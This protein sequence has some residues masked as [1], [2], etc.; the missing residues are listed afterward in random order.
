MNRYLF[1]ICSNTDLQI[2]RKNI[3]MAVKRKNLVLNFQKSNISHREGCDKLLV[4]GDCYFYILIS[5]YPNE[6]DG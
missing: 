3:E 4:V 2:E 1:G 6:L 5:G